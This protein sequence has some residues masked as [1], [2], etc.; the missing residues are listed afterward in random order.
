MKNEDFKV[1]Q[2]IKSF[3]FQPMP[4]RGDCYL[5]GVI[6]EVNIDITD[7]GHPYC[8]YVVTVTKDVSQGVEIADESSRVGT[9][10]YVPME[11]MFSEYDGRVTL[12]EG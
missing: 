2:K 1:G 7:N 10:A 12:V 3:D 5:E 9:T 8:H 11:C 6:R 4:G